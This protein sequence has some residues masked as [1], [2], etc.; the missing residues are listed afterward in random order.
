MPETRY[1]SPVSYMS[2]YSAFILSEET[3]YKGQEIKST[4]MGMFTR[5]N[6]QM[7]R[8]IHKEEQYLV[9]YRRV[10]KQMDDKSIGKLEEPDDLKTVKTV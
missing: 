7:L 4:D 2:S 6:E 10:T 3:K 9:K 1:K 8:E 5:D